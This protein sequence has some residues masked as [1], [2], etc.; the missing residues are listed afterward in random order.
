M[1]QSR[2]F[3]A[4]RPDPGAP[5]P[6][7][8]TDGVAA[9]AAARDTLDRL[10]ADLDAIEAAIEHLESTD[11]RPGPDASVWTEPMERPLQSGAPPR[12][13]QSMGFALDKLGQWTEGPEFTVDADRTK[14]YAAATN[15]PIPAHV[16]GE[17][18]PPVF[19]VV[20]I[21]D[22]MA[23][24]MATVVSPDIILLVVH[25]EQDMRFHRPITPGMV[26]RSKA[27]P[28]GVHVKPNG[29]TVVV[30]VETS[31]QTGALVVEQ[32][33]TS[34]FRGVSEGE[35]AGE[36]APEHKLTAETK[37]TP[38]VATVTQ[39]LDS[40]Q[41]YRYAEA[42]GDH[43]PIHLDAEVARSVGL[44]G[45]IIHGLCTMAFTSVA[46]VQELCGGDSAKLRRLAVRFSRPVLP[47]QQITTTFWAAGGRGGSRVFGY[48][49]RNGDGDVV[50]KDGLV[51]VAGA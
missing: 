44:P 33:M 47:G 16:D 6:A 40:D 42:S 30:K 7:P 26:L 20:P 34:F 23:G 9:V 11:E 43:M 39:T 37:A 1:D 32:Y 27:A 17:V 49:T 4:A 46:A 19:A 8:A 12:E 3:D 2:S 18:A 15:D 45:I 22:T 36:E 14:A 5:A 29:T 38:P 31:D 13:E 51:E 48:E 41:T 35:S 10:E 25:G 24:T 50:I 21:W 28:V